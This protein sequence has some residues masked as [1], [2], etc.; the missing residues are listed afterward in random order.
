[1]CG[2]KADSEKG[3][4]L[5]S[6]FLWPHIKITTMK[7]FLRKI[8]GLFLRGVRASRE[9]WTQCEFQFPRRLGE[10]TKG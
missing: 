3:N 5:E 2:R 10:R 7:T 1:M 4:G 8:A 6:V 9:H